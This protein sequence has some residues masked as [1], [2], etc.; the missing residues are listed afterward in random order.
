MIDITKCRHKKGND[1]IKTVNLETEDIYMFLTQSVYLLKY[2][3][4]I[5]PTIKHPTLFSKHKFAV[6]E[7]L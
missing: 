4:D 1:M 2:Q 7:F 5:P 3:M 6:I